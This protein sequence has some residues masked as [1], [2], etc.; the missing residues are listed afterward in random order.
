MGLFA[1]SASA[2]LVRARICVRSPPIRVVMICFSSPRLLIQL[3]LLRSMRTRFGSECAIWMTQPSYHNQPFTIAIIISWD[4]RTPWRHLYAT[5]Y[6]SG[7]VAR[8]VGELCQT[9]WLFDTYWLLVCRWSAK[10]RRAALLDRWPAVSVRPAGRKS[11]S[12]VRISACCC[13]SLIANAR[14]LNH[15]IVDLS[16]PDRVSVNIG[17]SFTSSWR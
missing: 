13:P 2:C 12:S 8:E 10:W 15:F 1:C 7:G 3:L 16:Q 17:I 4:Q 14:V 11:V 9:F 6:N 5:L